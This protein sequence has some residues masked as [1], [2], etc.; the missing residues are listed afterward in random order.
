MK[1]YSFEWDPPKHAK[2]LK[3]H[4]VSFEIAQHAFA[5]PFRIIA[6]DIKH[7]THL[8]K[9]FFCYGKVR[10]SVMTVRFTWRS[11]TIRIIGAGYWREGRKKYHEKNNLH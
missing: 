3:K 10:E 5:D 7:S 9:R 6:F 1:Q 2:N 4:Q 11:N 8:E